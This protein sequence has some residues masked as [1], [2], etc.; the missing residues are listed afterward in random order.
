MVFCTSYKRSLTMT[1]D[2]RIIQSLSSVKGIREL[3]QRFNSLA[4]SDKKLEVKIAM[5]CVLARPEPC[6]PLETGSLEQFPQL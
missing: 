5:A 6:L 3:T 1:W 2:L 4:Y